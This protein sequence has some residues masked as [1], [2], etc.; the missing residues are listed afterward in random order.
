MLKRNKKIKDVPRLYFIILF[1]AR[2]NPRKIKP[3]APQGRTLL[4]LVLS[5]T[6]G[7]GFVNK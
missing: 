3:I 5:F 2:P 6:R 4:I 1:T 7:R